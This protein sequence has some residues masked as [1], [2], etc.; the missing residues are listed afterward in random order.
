[1]APGDNWYP[2]AIEGAIAHIKRVCEWCQSVYPDPRI[3]A[4]L[5]PTPKIQILTVKTIYGLRIR[6]GAGLEYPQVGSLPYRS[7]RAFTRRTGDWG[8]V[9][10]GAWVTLDPRY[11]NLSY[12]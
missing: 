5:D 10:V 8:E 6:S 7:Q 9:G 2:Q 3:A 11:V 1:M 12:L 4:I